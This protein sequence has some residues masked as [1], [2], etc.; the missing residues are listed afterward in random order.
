MTPNMMQG[1]FSRRF[2][3]RGVGSRSSV[4]YNVEA[5]S[6][7]PASHS[8]KTDVSM[9]S[10]DEY[11][12]G[13]GGVLYDMILAGKAAIEFGWFSDPVRAS[14]ASCKRQPH[15][16]M[17]VHLHRFFNALRSETCILHC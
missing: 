8:N 6:T 3:K 17:E 1:R 15:D 12:S 7:A 16:T 4:V 9:T 5:N 11:E 2:A 13:D 14:D 10:S